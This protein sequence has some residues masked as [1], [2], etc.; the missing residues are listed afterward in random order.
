M[1]GP[2]CTGEASATRVSSLRRSRFQALE[3]LA[4]TS[5]RAGLISQSTHLSATRKI[6]CKL[7]PTGLHPPTCHERLTV[8]HFPVCATPQSCIRP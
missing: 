6:P 1:P 3:T 2:V 7:I 8:M 4:H 5:S